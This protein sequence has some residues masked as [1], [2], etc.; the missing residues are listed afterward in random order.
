M[1][2]SVESIR[3]DRSWLG[4]P[5]G[6]IANPTVWL[7]VSATALLAVGTACHL[8][9]AFP[10]LATIAI[11]AVA[12]YV[13]FTPLH[14]AMHGVAHEARWIN[15][16]IGRVAGLALT[17]TLPL[18]RGV[19]F[20]HHSHTNDPERD[21]DLGVARRPRWLLPLWCGLIPTESRL[22][23]YGR[24]LWRSRG[25]LV[26]ALAVDVLV[27]GVLLA[28]LT[29]TW[30]M[31]LVVVWLAPAAIAVLILAF[32]FDFLPHYPYDRRERYFDTRIQPGA[33]RNVV[34]LGQ[35]HH[36]IHHLWT[37]IPWF[38]YQPV[39][40]AIR[41][42]LARRGCRI[43][44]EPRSVRRRPGD[45]PLEP[46]VAPEQLASGTEAGGAEDVVGN[47]GVGLRP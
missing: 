3:V 4:A 18:F 33:V 40:L 23:F 6:T 46:I 43:G 5:A 34:L 20:E 21:P 22:A 42:D 28:T 39:F 8:T 41:D 1:P 30:A 13:I 17:I 31:T 44:D 15:A 24:R 47:R 10:A 26:E 35:N 32:A 38:R 25:Q 45:G 29:T 7:F 36:L 14:E 9:G 12:L 37:T 11:N 19:H 27:T 16:A 2:A